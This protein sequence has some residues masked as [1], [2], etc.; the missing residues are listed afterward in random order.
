MSKSRRAAGLVRLLSIG[1]RVL[2]LLEFRVR[3]RLADT[4]EKLAGWYAG[5][6]KRTTSRPTAE[7]LL[8]A[9]KH[10]HVSIILLEQRLYR[11]LTPLSPL[12]QHILSLLE[13]PYRAV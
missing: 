1:L 4:Q 6:P 2:T 7:A 11:H 3:E 9:F 12:Q 5:N 13:I 8:A 10:I